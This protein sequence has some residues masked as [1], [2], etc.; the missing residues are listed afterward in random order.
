MK[1]NKIT[2]QLKDKAIWLV[3]II[4]V[5]AFTIANE[6]QYPYIVT[7]GFYVWYCIYRYDVCH[8]A[9]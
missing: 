4:L 6:R 7:S 2:N 8:F 1:E 3:L 9:W 5:I